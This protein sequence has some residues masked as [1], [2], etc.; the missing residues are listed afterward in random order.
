MSTGL[1][2]ETNHSELWAGEKG[3]CFFPVILGFQW[4]RKRRPFP[5]LSSAKEEVMNTNFST[6]FQPSQQTHGPPGIRMH[7]LLNFCGHTVKIWRNSLYV[8]AITLSAKELW[9]ICH[10]NLHIRLH[11]KSYNM[12]HSAHVGVLVGSCDCSTCTE[13]MFYIKL[14]VTIVCSERLACQLPVFIFPNS[15]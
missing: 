6:N 8:I 12:I 3:L 4:K 9:P 15:M 10:E 5:T 7:G 11:T 2:T 13:N 1:W 14:L